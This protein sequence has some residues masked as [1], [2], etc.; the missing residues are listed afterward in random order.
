MGGKKDHGV[1]SLVRVQR[2]PRAGPPREDVGDAANPVDGHQSI[3]GCD[4]NAHTNPSGYQESEDQNQES[5]IQP[6][7]GVCHSWL[8]TPDP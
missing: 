8:L 2:D 5:G 6:E 3:A 1:A 7:P 4:E